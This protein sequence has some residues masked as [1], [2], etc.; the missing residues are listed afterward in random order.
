MEETTE[1]KLLNDNEENK[2]MLI[3]NSNY[4]MEVPGKNEVI[5]NQN[6]EAGEENLNPDE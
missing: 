5:E 6:S 4:L 1:M 2:N 3:R